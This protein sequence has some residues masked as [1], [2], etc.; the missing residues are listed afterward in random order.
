[1]N[2][3]CKI[4]IF[5]IFTFG[6][7]SNSSKVTV[8]KEQPAGI[9]TM[10]GF[11]LVQTLN[12]DK[13]LEVKADEAEVYEREKIIKFYNV[14]AK[15]FETDKETSNLTS[16]KGT[17]NTVTNDMEVAGNVVL[18]T[19]D[20][21]KLETSELKWIDKASKLKTDK[22]VRVTKGDNVMT[23]IGMESDLMLENVQI[24]KV[25]TKITD[26]DSLKEENKK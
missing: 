7:S 9:V 6:C 14:S 12:G 26:L 10:K 13:R 5:C 22:I 15:Y 11:H 21:S 2:K 4:F 25:T 17:I 19:K 3:I 8:I 16:K 18:I 1:M 23:G 24:R 20:N